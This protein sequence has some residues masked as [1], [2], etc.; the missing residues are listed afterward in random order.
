VATGTIHR[1]VL[2]VLAV[3]VLCLAGTGAAGHGGV[4]EE[5][6][7]CVI[8]I[9]YL[10][11]HF[12]IYQP[13]SE[14][15]R[16][17]CE[18]LPAAT[19][20]V[21]VMEY[22]HDAMTETPIEFRIIRDVTGKG[23]FARWEDVAGIDDLDAATVFYRPPTVEPDVYTAVHTF[24]EE[25]D[26]IGI[27]TV[28][29]GDRGEVYRAVFPFEVG[30][31]GFGYWPLIVAVVL[32]I[33]L[34]YLASSGRLGKWWRAR[35]SMPAAGVA[36]LLAAMTVPGLAGETVRSE[37]GHFAVSWTS[38]L[39]PIEINRIHSWQLCVRDSDGSP[40]DGAEITIDGGMPAH[41]HGLPTQPRVTGELGDGCY[42]ID[43]LRFHMAGAW[44]LR[45]TITAGGVTEAAVIPLEL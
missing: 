7:V 21:F 16:Q 22:L 42:R 24:D 15:H 25:G 9:N 3:F 8:R 40:V 17:Y 13:R 34:Q 43:G 41:N 1:R 30:F 37:R 36:L 11:G 2:R 6:D 28:A 18:D 12:K 39:E 33:Q 5:D 23:R 45:I 26:Y 31:T 29:V 4:V 44:Q 27:V 10:K 20:S 19:E 38:E 32:L 14:G 35:R